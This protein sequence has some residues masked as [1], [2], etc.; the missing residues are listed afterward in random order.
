M[1]NS[2]HRKL[3][4]SSDI[5]MPRLPPSQCG[6]FTVARQ[7][8]AAAGR[9]AGRVISNHKHAASLTLNYSAAVYLACYFTKPSCILFHT[10][11]I[12][13]GT[14]AGSSWD[15]GGRRP[16]PGRMSLKVR[17]MGV[18]SKLRPVRMTPG[19]T[20]DDNRMK[21]MPTR[22]APLWSQSDSGKKTGSIARCYGWC[23]HKECLWS[24]LRA[25]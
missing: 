18:G 23:A 12:Q 5:L 14:A 19:M 15:P 17:G 13:R 1:Q 11:C 25:S 24:S 22:W 7:Q 6:H 3:Q 20:W 10:L 21:G 9:Q 2:G 4:M 16:R 8:A